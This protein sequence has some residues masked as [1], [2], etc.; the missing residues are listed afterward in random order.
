M[1]LEFAL[2]A[3]LP[4][5]SSVSLASYLTTLSIRVVPILKHDFFGCVFERMGG[6]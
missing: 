4:R 1:L 2:V 6:R 5:V 3:A